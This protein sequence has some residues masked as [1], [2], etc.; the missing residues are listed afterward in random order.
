MQPCK[1]PNNC[2]QHVHSSD[3]KRVLSE[4]FT[5]TGKHAFPPQPL[6]NFEWGYLKEVIGMILAKSHFPSL[7]HNF[8][9]LSFASKHRQTGKPLEKHRSC[10]A[11]RD[12]GLYKVL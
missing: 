10:G 12:K 2:V 5:V 7:S 3:C 6:M 11:N 8:C 1:G 9:P 4:Q